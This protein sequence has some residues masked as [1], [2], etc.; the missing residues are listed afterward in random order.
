MLHRRRDGPITFTVFFFFLKPIYFYSARLVSELILYDKYGPKCLILSIGM[1]CTCSLAGVT[2]WFIIVILGI[3]ILSSASDIDEY[4]FFFL[5]FTETLVCSDIG[6]ASEG[7]NISIAHS[8][9]I[10]S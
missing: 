3:G 4:F 9:Q 1:P 10:P 5:K 7:R 6:K 8:N 2:G